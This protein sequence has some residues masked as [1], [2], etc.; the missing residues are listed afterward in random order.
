MLA[1]LYSITNITKKDSIRDRLYIS[2][3][4]VKR[5]NNRKILKAIGQHIKSLRLAANLTLQQVHMATGIS[6]TNI[7]NMEVGL[8]NSTIVQMSIYA[9]LYGMTLHELINV[10]LLPPD[11]ASLRAVVKKFIKGRGMD[12]AIFFQPSERITNIFEN[13]LLKTSFLT[14]PRFSSE[15]AAYCREKYGVHF[16]STQ[17]SRAFDNLFNKGLIQKLPTDKKSKFQYRKHSVG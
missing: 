4:G 5:Q 17:V 9:E 12:P 1:F 13:K 15:V 11:E 2:I 16:S 3:W 8:L 7:R 10:T 6:K 14:T